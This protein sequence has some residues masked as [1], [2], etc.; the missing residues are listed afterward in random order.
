MKQNIITLG[1]A[2]LTSTQECYSSGEQECLAVLHAIQKTD[3]YVRGA[4]KIV[5]YSDNKNTCDYFKMSLHDIKNERILKFREKLLGYPLELVHVKGA[6]HTLADRLSRY[7]NKK[8][9]YTDLHDRF[10][11]SIAS[12]Y[13]RT[14][15]SGESPTDPHINEIAKIAK[16]DDDYMYM[17]RCIKEKRSIKSIKDDSE[18]KKIQGQYNNLSLYKT[19]EG[20]IIIRDSQDIFIPK[21]YRN[22]PLTTKSFPLPLNYYSLTKFSTS[23]TCR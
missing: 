14:K 3:F 23:T 16:K 18:L 7:P 21:N 10:T 5:V 2:G 13:L 22:H 15:E 1:S 19:D 11:P 17:V 20:E 9:T 8:N 12:R 4:R 6:T